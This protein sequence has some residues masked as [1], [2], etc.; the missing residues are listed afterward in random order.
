MANSCRVTFS[1]ASHA[2]VSPN[3]MLH[4]QVKRLQ[5]RCCHSFE[6]QG[7]LREAQTASSFATR[8]STDQGPPGKMLLWG[9]LRR[10]QPAGTHGSRL[11]DFFLERAGFEECM[12]GLCLVLE[13]V[14]ESTGGGPLFSSPST[15]FSRPFKT[16]AAVHTC[17]HRLLCYFLS[18]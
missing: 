13:D 8:R 11:A 12:P 14:E 3:A 6:Q 1:R 4:G 15:T 9:R 18:N 17:S 10:R 16:R 5:T 2:L 7:H